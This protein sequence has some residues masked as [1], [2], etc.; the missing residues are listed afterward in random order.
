MRISDPMTAPVAAPVSPGAG[1]PG[2][3]LRGLAVVGLT[4]L[5]GL[6]LAA[7]PAVAEDA[8]PTPD[9]TDVAASAPAVA[10]GDPLVITPENALTVGV[11]AYFAGN[12]PDALRGFQMAADHGNAIA[13]WKLAKMYA[14]GD[15]VDEDDRRAFD[16]FRRIADAHADDSPESPMAPVYAS[17][18]VELGSYYLHG[19]EGEEDSHNPRRAVSLLRHAAS[20]FGDAD[21]Q[22][23]L[24]RLY[25][26]GDT[27]ERDPLTA[28]RW[29]A[30]S[31]R[32]GNVPAQALLGDLLISGVDVPP[33]RVDGLK[34]LFIAE[35]HAGPANRD[36]VLSLLHKAESLVSPE[37]LDEAERRASAWLA[38]QQG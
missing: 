15:G 14:D 24:A 5:A 31:A 33:D 20:Y 18:F 17:A 21:A 3:A 30:L 12:I 2:L 36:W 22:Y 9:A 13:L 6:C 10:T 8:I 29:L 28:A 35:A 1:L 16:Y 25:L 19:I 32:E 4:M 26:A 37:Q 27:V 23:R 34:W 38:K 7:L 11:R